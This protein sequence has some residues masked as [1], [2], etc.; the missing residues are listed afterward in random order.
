MQDGFHR[1]PRGTTLVISRYPVPDEIATRVRGNSPAGPGEGIVWGDVIREISPD[2]EVLWEWFSHEHLA[3]EQ[4]KGCPLCPPQQWTQACG[5]LELKDGN[6]LVCFRRTNT[7]AIIEKSS[8]NLRWRWG[9]R[10]LA[11][12]YGPVLLDNGH[13][14]LFDSG[15]HRGGIDMANSRIL[16]IVPYTGEIVWSYAESA[17]QLFYASTLSTCQ[18][19][20]NG[21]TLIAEGTTGRVFEVSG[22]GE[23][24][25]EWVND[26]G[27]ANPVPPFTRHL[28]VAVAYRYGADYSGLPG[29]A[30]GDTACPQQ[31]PG[32]DPPSRQ[33]SGA[34]QK[35]KVLKRLRQLGY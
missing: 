13:I 16:E 32:N 25:W 19:L 24:V 7:L 22:A 33:K 27:E 23:T 21:N 17:P 12:P 26:L 2:R 8:G 9:E 4:E 34:A 11:H 10:E 28:P 29:Q 18:R 30:H 3:P 1:T 15:Y 35:D 20:P 6:I 31:A 5:C 14:L